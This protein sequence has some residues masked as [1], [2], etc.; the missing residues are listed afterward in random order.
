[1]SLTKEKSSVK[2]N[3]GL[4]AEEINSQTKQQVKMFFDSYDYKPK[5]NVVVVGD[6]PVAKSYLKAL[7]YAADQTEIGLS[8][9]RFDDVVTQERILKEIHF[10]NEDKSIN[11]Y[12]LLL[13]FPEHLDLLDLRKNILESKDIDGMS[14]ETT[15]KIKSNGL[16]LFWPATALGCFCVVKTRFPD[17]LKGKVVTVVG[18]SDIV[19]MPIS[20]LLAKDGADILG[21]DSR[22]SFLHK[23]HACQQADILISC[24]GKPTAHK[25]L[26]FYVKKGAMLIDIGMSVIPHGTRENAFRFV[27]DIDS[28]AELFSSSFAQTL[29]G[30]GPVTAAMM[31]KN[32]LDAAFRQHN[33]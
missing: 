2:I 28:A 1:M 23:I 10:L 30:V 12:F 11:G 5:M 24:V 18:L 26:D 29:N 7:Y 33:L 19:G 21:V 17:S 27:G 20:K 13:P 32:V 9:S 14:L 3:G 16:N 31:M 4:I 25:I 15:Q 8:E 6:D 22:T